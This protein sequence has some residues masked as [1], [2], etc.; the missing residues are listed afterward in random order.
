MPPLHEYC[1][2]CRQFAAVDIV[3]LRQGRTGMKQHAICQR[4]GHSVRATRIPA[5]LPPAD[6]PHQRSLFDQDTDQ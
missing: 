5:I 3:H 2:H 6:P 4:C 1:P